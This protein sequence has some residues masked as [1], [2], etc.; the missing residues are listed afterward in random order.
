MLSFMGRP[1]AKRAAEEMKNAKHAKQNEKRGR[2]YDS[3]SVLHLSLHVFHFAF[4]P[5]LIF[6]AR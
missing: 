1:Q 6:T 4:S 3:S 5:S 2:R